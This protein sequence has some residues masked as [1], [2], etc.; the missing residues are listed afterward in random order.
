MFLSCEQELRAAVRAGGLSDRVMFTGYV[1]NVQ[2]YLQA[3]DAFVFPSEM[4]AFGLAPLEAAACGL[5]VTSTTAGALAQTMEDGK[6]ALTFPVGDALALCRQMDLIHNQTN[7]RENLAQEGLSR[8]R[9]Q[10]SLDA[11]AGKH[12]Q[13]FSEMLAE[14]R[15]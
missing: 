7:L 3:S 15:A 10:Y 12:A 4:E 5:P 1:E 2:E 9:S 8:V 14:F 13:F 6:N 11:V